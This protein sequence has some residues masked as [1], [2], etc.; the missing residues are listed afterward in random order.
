MCLLQDD[1]AG[2][3]AECGDVPDMV[4]TVTERISSKRRH[5]F[6]PVWAAAAALIIMAASGY[7]L[8]YAHNVHGNNVVIAPAPSPT[9]SRSVAAS[10]EK[11][12][13]SGQGCPEKAGKK[14]SKPIRRHYAIAKSRRQEPATSDR[15]AKKNPEPAPLAVEEAEVTVEYVDGVTA[16]RSANVTALEPTGPIPPVHDNWANG[17]VVA[18]R[19]LFSSNGVLT[20]RF[21][22]RQAQPQS[23]GQNQIENTIQEPS[24]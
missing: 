10:P 21:Y 15:T 19:E 14:H 22:Y 18:E 24:K 20:D 7:T 4:S 5:A 23:D 6:W 12:L 17:S 3:L 11:P 8:F 2:A 13:V 1:I 9:H 16:Q